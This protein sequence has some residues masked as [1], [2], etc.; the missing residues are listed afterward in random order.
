VRKDNP[1]K[2]IGMISKKDIIG[3]YHETSRK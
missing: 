2:I 3:Y 1:N